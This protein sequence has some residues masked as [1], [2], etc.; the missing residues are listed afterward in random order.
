ML[1]NI[2]PVPEGGTEPPPEPAGETGAPGPTHG[3]PAVSTRG[4]L[5]LRHFLTDSLTSQPERAPLWFGG[6]L[7]SPLRPV[8]ARVSTVS[9]VLVVVVLWSY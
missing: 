4:G 7:M 5:S 2:N 9:G 8:R 3:T 6:I 1:I